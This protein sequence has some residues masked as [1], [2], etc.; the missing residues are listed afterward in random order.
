[1]GT[2]IHP[3]KLCPFHKY[4]DAASRVHNPGKMIIGE[5][6]HTKTSKIIHAMTLDLPLILTNAALYRQIY[7]L[8]PQ[9]LLSVPAAHQ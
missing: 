3:I 7:R 6:V 2:L 5:K 9:K 8:A 1:M 4:P